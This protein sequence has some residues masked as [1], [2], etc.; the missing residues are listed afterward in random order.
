LRH[1]QND[2]ERKKRRIHQAILAIDAVLRSAGGDSISDE[3]FHAVIT[4]ELELEVPAGASS[5]L[6]MRR[7]HEGSATYLQSAMHSAEAINKAGATRRS[8]A[9]R[10]KRIVVVLS[11][12]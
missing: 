4:K 8:K 2:D 7:L 11:D 6:L 3:R 10:K 12:G 9:D 1:T 5:R